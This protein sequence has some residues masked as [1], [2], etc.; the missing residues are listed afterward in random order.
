MQMLLPCAVKKRN[1][2]PKFKSITYQFS[3]Y[4]LQLYLLGMTDWES[5]HHASMG[6]KSSTV[7]N[8]YDEKGFFFRQRRG[9][10]NL[11]KLDSIDMDR[12][13]REVDVDILQQHLEDLTFCLFNEE[14]LEYF[15]DRQVVK[16][17]RLSQLTIEYL[18]YSQGQLVNN[19]G[20]ISKK[21]SVKKK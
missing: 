2:Q 13:I 4:S 1:G 11:R 21:Y 18:L 5:D 16:M 14:D 20:E 17:F 12:M 6:L 10:L 8:L 9:R 19:L 3:Q 7:D 15:T